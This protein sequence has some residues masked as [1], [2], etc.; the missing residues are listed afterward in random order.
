MGYTTREFE[1]TAFSTLYPAFY[2]ELQI[3][4]WTSV[5]V[6]ITDQNGRQVDLPPWP[7]AYQSQFVEIAVRECVGSRVNEVKGRF[8]DKAIPAKQY[9]VSLEDIILYPIRL[10]ECG[11]IISTKEH[12]LVAKDMV[13]DSIY[14]PDNSETLADFEITDPRFVFE[15]RD[16][17]N[18][19]D[20]LYVNVLGQT[21]TISCSHAGRRIADID[22]TQ[23]ADLAD[24]CTLSCYL[25]YPSNY[26]QAEREVVPVFT[27]NLNDLD[28]ERPYQIQSGDI[29]CVASTLESLQRVIQKKHEA[30]NSIVQIT[31]M[32]SKEMH[33]NIV[34]NL[35]KQIETEKRT[36]TEQI[37]IARMQKDA[38]IASLK[39]EL[40][41]EKRKSATTQQQLEYW[42]DLHESSI[43]RLSREDKLISAR[44]RMERE[45]YDASRKASDD[46]ITLLKVG[47][48]A[49]AGIATFVITM[50]LKSK[51]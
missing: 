22:E 30:S 3:N 38:E 29:I 24:E 7:K 4:N 47:G 39:A 50:L 2:R 42:H 28:R 5:T 34:E 9:T 27:I 51:K 23:V 40:D 17:F 12:A 15:V 33:D 49:A 46:T 32:I 36:A 8:V 26:A 10:E 19:W 44:E 18:R 35:Q 21:I 14:S 13:D 37:R 6:T 48:A 43:D 31:G 25:R 45:S 16:P 20:K 1:S 11:L 41:K